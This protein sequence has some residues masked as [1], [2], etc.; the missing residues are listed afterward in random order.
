MPYCYDPEAIEEIRERVDCLLSIYQAFYSRPNGPS[1][2]RLFSYLEES[3]AGHTPGPATGEAPREG[4][5][6]L[7]AELLIMLGDEAFTNAFESRFDLAGLSTAGF[8]GDE[9]ESNGLAI[10]GIAGYEMFTLHQAVQ[11]YS[12]VLDRFY[13]MAPVISAA[14]D[15]GSPA[16]PRNFLSA[17]TVTTYFDRLIRASTQRS[18]AYAEIARRYQGFN[19]AGLARRVAVRAYNQ[20]YLETIALTNVILRLHEI[21]GGTNRPQLIIELEKAQQR[22]SMALLDLVNVYQS[23]TD[24]VNILGFAPDY[25][26]FPALGTGGANVDVNAFEWIYQFVQTKLEVA[27]RREQTALAETRSFDT[28]EASFQAEL[29]RL[30]RTYESQLGDLCGFFTGDDGLVYPATEDSAFRSDPFIFARALTVAQQATAARLRREKASI[31]R[32][33]ARWVELQQCEIART[34]IFHEAQ[35]QLLQ[36]KEGELSMLAAHLRLGLALSEVAKSR[37]VARRLQLEMQE[38]IELAIDAKAAKNDPNIRIY[39]ND[40]PS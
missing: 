12:M 22:Y 1:D 35:N 36:L 6:K 28:D 5:E 10:S 17:D 23:I 27:R 8:P 39:R 14:L 26:P 13:G 24:E 31:E 9:F 7:Y 29:T 2:A 34:E 11:Y 21:S 4:F 25:V 15:S 16:L 40:A 37:Q 18:R 19:Q 30:S 20:T 33:S 38:S 3:F 32:A